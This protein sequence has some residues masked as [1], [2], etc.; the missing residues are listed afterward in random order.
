MR[1]VLGHGMDGMLRGF[2]YIAAAGR[3]LAA[4]KTAS[5]TMLGEAVLVGRRTDGDVFAF[6]NACP[7]RGMPLHHGKFEGDVLRCG[8]HGWTFESRTGQCT[9]IPAEPLDSAICPA[10]FR[11]KQYPCREHQGHVW[12]FMAAPGPVPDPLPDV[13]T[14]A[15]FGDAAP[16]AGITMRFPCHVDLAVIGFC[17]PGHPAFVHTSS[18]W[19]SK[20]HL[21]LRPKEKRFEPDGHGFSMARH[22][23]KGGGLPYKLLGGDVHATIGLQLPGMRTELVEGRSHKAAI[24]TAVTP[25]GPAETDVHVYAFWTLPWLAPAKPLARWLMR[26]FLKQ[27]R[28]IAVR[29]AAHPPTR[30]P[31]YIGDA[32]AQIRWYLQLKKEHAVSAA[33]GRAFENPLRAQTLRWRS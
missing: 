19:K 11:L 23:V 21:R 9:E 12:V 24:V 31:M 17:D 20:P 28:E 13:P 18:W 3:D 4:G 15:A 8:F 10:R 26:D 7:H 16:Q 25:V 33:E 27:D 1:P 29:M 30:S 6:N 32:D 2:W 14:V 5:R 22:A